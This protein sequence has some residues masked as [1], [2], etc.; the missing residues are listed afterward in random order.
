MDSFTKTGATR[1]ASKI[2]L[3]WALKGV[4]GVKTWI[5]TVPEQPELYEVRSNVAE[6]LNVHSDSH[7]SL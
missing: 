4:S 1:I 2:A 6:R 7:A 3:Y 5:R